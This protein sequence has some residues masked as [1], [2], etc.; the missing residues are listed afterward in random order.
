[1][2]IKHHTNIHAI[3]HEANNRTKLEQYTR[4]EIS[5]E[6]ILKMFYMLLRTRI[7]KKHSNRSYG[8]KDT[9]TDKFA[10]PK[11]LFYKREP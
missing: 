1:M 2:I 7:R 8:E 11:D 5:S 9:S 3:T 6:K 4:C 10:L